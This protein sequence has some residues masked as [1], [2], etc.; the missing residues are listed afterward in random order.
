MAAP[1]SQPTE[2]QHI[3]KPAVR[4][5]RQEVTD[6][7]VRMLEQGVLEC[8]RCKKYCRATPRG[9]SRASERLRCPR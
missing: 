6:N 5:F 8:S 1:I 9:A 2:G 7:I 4:D 3:D